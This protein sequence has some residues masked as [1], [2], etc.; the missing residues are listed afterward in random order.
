MANNELDLDSMWIRF[1]T[2]GGAVDLPAVNGK[3]GLNGV[4]EIKL[5]MGGAISGA[6]L[7]RDFFSLVLGVDVVGQTIKQNESS[8]YMKSR[9]FVT[10]YFFPFDPVRSDHILRFGVSPVGYSSF[11]G[12]EAVYPGLYTRA[13]EFTTNNYSLN[14]SATYF[15][16]PIG[17]GVS[18]DATADLSVTGKFNNDRA[19]KSRGLDTTAEIFWQPFLKNKDWLNRLFLYGSYK[20]SQYNL[21]YSEYGSSWFGGDVNW[22][23]VTFGLKYDMMVAIK[24]LLKTCLNSNRLAP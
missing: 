22:R 14:A 5:S 10:A 18:L 16:K 8:R 21:S 17:L 2:S 13:P 9:A 1:S 6:H 15:Y 11:N 4:N 19:Y 23:Q 7:V 24:N 20:Y 12:V 3:R